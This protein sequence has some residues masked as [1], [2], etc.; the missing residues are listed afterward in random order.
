[1]N[2]IEALEIREKLHSIP[3]VAH[4]EKETSELVISFLEQFRPT[5]IFKNVGGYG[6]V[7]C[8]QGNRPGHSTMFR[9]ELDA[10]PGPGGPQHLC[11]HDG[12]MTILLMLAKELQEN[13]DF[14]GIVYLL[15]QPAE[16]NGEGAKLMVKDINNLGIKFDYSIAMHNNPNYELN[17]IIIH[18]GTYAPASVGVEILFEG[19]PSHAAY[20][21][22]ANSPLQAIIGMV[23]EVNKIGN[24]TSLF[25][26]FVLS[27]VVNLQLGEVNYGVTPGKGVI[28]LT[29]RANRDNDLETFKSAVKRAAE[30]TASANN[31]KIEISYHDYFP[32]TINNDK[33]N[34]LLMSSA[35]NLNFNI[36]EAPL[37]TRGSDDF[38]HFSKISEILFFDIGNGKGVDIHEPAYKFN[39]GIIPEAVKLYLNLIK[40]L[41]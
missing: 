5:Q 19:T 8:F 27:T 15:F 22:K 21:E 39:D 13:P 28:R 3:E 24:N 20:P 16:E 30:K 29:L 35:K 9:C 25:G 40:Q 2:Q 33:L 37:P 38:S 17:N 32:A 6:I 18:H 34:S 10:V 14:P 23:A 12:H 4:C 11:G 26:D 41:G 31:L 1:M 7:A 36:T